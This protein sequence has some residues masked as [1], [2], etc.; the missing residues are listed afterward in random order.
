M[1]KK[2]KLIK[3]HHYFEHIVKTCEN[4]ECNKSCFAYVVVSLQRIMSTLK[5]LRYDFF[6]LYEEMAWSI[7]LLLKTGKGRRLRYFLFSI[8]R[9]YRVT[10]KGK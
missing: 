9:N 4:L 6:F 8:F 3:N 5:K 10:I 7:V 2:K 1:F